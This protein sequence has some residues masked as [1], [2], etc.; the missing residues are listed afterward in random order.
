MTDFMPFQDAWSHQ[1]TSEV[2]F[3]LKQNEYMKENR[4]YE[5]LRILHNI[6]L[7]LETVCKLEPLLH[8]GAE[9]T[10][11]INNLAHPATMSDALDLLD[12]AGVIVVDDHENVSGDYDFCLDCGAEFADI[13][14][15]KLGVVELTRSGAL[16]Y[17]KRDTSIPVLS[18]DDS[19]TKCLETHFGTG[20]GFL[21]A[22]LQLT[23]E[24]IRDKKFVIFGFGKVG[25]GV[26]HTLS[27][28]T[29]DVIAIDIDDDALAS[30]E[31]YGVTTLHLGNDRKAVEDAISDAFAVV[32]ATGIK[33]LISKNFSDKGLFEGKYLSNAGINEFGD[34]FSDD[35]VLYSKMW[36]INFALADP[37][38]MRY[39]DPSFYAHNMGPE[40]IMKKKLGPGYHYLPEDI[41]NAIVS[42]WQD[43]YGENI[44]LI[45]DQ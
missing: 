9:I 2:P 40:I 32:C 33:D 26:A 12:K 14:K 16:V 11:T 37:T 5:G 8:S 29:E 15:P 28:Y 22:F 45:I 24:D 4:P 20:D 17:E 6:P 42:E 21:R 3:L 7:S 13:I 43:Y 25:K 36:P 35:D 31:R 44:S 30:G 18:I 41:D 23:Q 38:K 10:V 19:T 1:S 27:M 39:L 34:M